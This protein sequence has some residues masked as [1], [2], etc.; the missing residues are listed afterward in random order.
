MLVPRV[1]LRLEVP[2][3]RVRQQGPSSALGP[4]NRAW[5]LGAREHLRAVRLGVILHFSF[6]VLGRR[7]GTWPGISLAYALPPGPK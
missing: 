6:G 2:G 4:P 1:F 3:A 5:P 7:P